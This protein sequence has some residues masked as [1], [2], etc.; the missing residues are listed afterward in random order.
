MYRV[1]RK[2]TVAVQVGP[3]F[4]AK[5][6]KSVGVDQNASSSYSRESRAPFLTYEALLQ[7]FLWNK[8]MTLSWLMEIGLIAEGRNCGICKNAMSLSP[9]NDRK[10]GVRWECR[11]T[12]GGKK[13]RSERSIREGSWF[14][15]ANLTISEVLKFTYWW[16]IGLNQVQIKAQ[17]GMSSSTLVDWDMFCRELCGIVLSHENEVIGGAGKII[18]IDESKIGKRKYN[19]GHFVEGQWVFGG[20][21]DDSRNSFIVCVENRKE[22][23]KEFHSCISG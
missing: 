19:K 2:K 18:Q 14:Q 21:E 23:R 20:I 11:H 22:D 6:D 16:C 12:I 5:E 7:R 17:L 10:D 8:D 1:I 15:G 3:S 9:C 13:H 4:M